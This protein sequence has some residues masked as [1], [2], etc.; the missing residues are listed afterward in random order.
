MR[1]NPC[2]AKLLC[3]ILCDT[4]LVSQNP[5]ATQYLCRKAQNQENTD[6]TK[7]RDWKFYHLISPEFKSRCV[8][9]YNNMLEIKIFRAD[10]ASRPQPGASPLDPARG[11]HPWNPA[12]QGRCPRTPVPNFLFYEVQWN[13]FKDY[14]YY[15]PHKPSPTGRTHFQTYNS[16]N[17]VVVIWTS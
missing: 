1:H 17:Q 14:Y 16:I 4:I 12:N 2:V 15:Y 5:L 3:R 13:E 6:F 7:C 10:L 11:C 9:H 8:F